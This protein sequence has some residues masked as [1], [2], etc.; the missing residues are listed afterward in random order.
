MRQ[1]A[2]C[3]RTR[4]TTKE[5]RVRRVLVTYG[6]KAGST[7]DVAE[8]IAAHLGRR[9]YST[10]L[11]PAGSVT[12][13]ADY[14]GVVLG[15]SIYTTRWHPDARRFLK[16]HRETLTRLPFAVFGM[17][18]LTTAEHDMKASRRQLDHALM[19]TP[20]LEPVTVAV[21]GGVVDPRK[22][23]FPFSHLPASDA[24][25]WDAIQAWADDVADLLESEVA[26]PA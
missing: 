23:T 12:S 13:L 16:R 5:A 25:D 21:F 18:P 9:F 7:R 2:P 4:E 3:A 26:V 8:S 14:D 19:K 24:R 1:D 17:G 15:G 22:L 6:T 20:E 10:D 11:E